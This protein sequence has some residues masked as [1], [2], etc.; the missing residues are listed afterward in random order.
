[1]AFGNARCVGIGNRE[2]H[3]LGVW[4]VGFSYFETNPH[5]GDLSLSNCRRCP[6]LLK[7]G[8]AVGQGEELPQPAT[9]A[10]SIGGICE[11]ALALG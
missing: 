4:G 8:Q 10:Q 9:S 11:Q 1:M 3:P 7:H 2:S 6:H 5:V